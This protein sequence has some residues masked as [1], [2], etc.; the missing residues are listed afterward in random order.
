M[1]GS[2]WFFGTLL[3]PY[4]TLCRYISLGDTTSS[5]AGVCDDGRCLENMVAACLKDLASAPHNWA[6]RKDMVS[7]LNDDQKGIAPGFGYPVT[8]VRLPRSADYP[9]APAGAPAARGSQQPGSTSGR[10]RERVRRRAARGGRSARDKVQ[11]A[12][13]AMKCSFTEHRNSAKHTFIEAS[14]LTKVCLRP[15]GR[16]GC[17]GA[18]AAPHPKSRLTSKRV[19]QFPRR[20]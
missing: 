10:R 9:P 3:C 8:E 4:L 19:S 11:H 18:C 2:L 12:A 14:R 13:A 16:L 17:C 7:S 1:F 15:V 6:L 5:V 20:D